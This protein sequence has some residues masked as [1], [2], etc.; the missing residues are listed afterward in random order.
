[1]MEE[2]DYMFWLG[3]VGIL[4]F[5]G[6]MITYLQNYASI[7][8]RQRVEYQCQQVMD[9]CSR[10]IASLQ[11]ANLTTDFR[12]NMVTRCRFYCENVNESG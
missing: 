10:A 12:P 2:K 11:Q 9:Q 8:E 4:V 7:K 6:I 5:F 3:I 1:M